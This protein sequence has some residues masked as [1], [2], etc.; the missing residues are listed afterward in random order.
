MPDRRRGLPYGT[1]I[2]SLL[3]H[4]DEEGAPEAFELNDQGNTVPRKAVT[5]IEVTRDAVRLTFAQG[6]GPRP[7]RVSLD[8]EIEIF[9]PPKKTSASKARLGALRVT[10]EASPAVTKKLRDVLTSP[11]KPAV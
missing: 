5:A 1:P 3:I 8:P 11:R 7:G 4:L 9:A 6:K 10:F 2:H